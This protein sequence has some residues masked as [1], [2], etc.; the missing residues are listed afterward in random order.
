HIDMYDPK[1][2]LKELNGQRPPAELIK[3]V[4]FAFIKKESVTLLGSPRTFTRHGQCG[5]DFSDQLPHLATCADDICMIRSIHT[6]Q[7]NHHPAQLLLS[8]G[9]PIFGFPSVG[10]W[11][12][13][14][15]GSVSQD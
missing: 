12:T 1:P 7:F 6:D 8:S 2:K 5:M 15:L 11:L 13:Y 4:R 14:G 9:R 3:N 10:S